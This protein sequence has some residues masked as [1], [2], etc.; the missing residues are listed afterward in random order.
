MKK[1][2]YYKPKS[3]AEVWELKDK[4]PNSRYIAGG[5]DVMVKI[6]SRLLAP[7]ALISLRDIPELK[8]IS[9][10]KNIR[11]GA[12][13]TITELIENIE[14][15]RAVPVL[16]EAAKRIGSLQ[17]R[18]V[19]TIG[20]NIGNCSPCAD[21]APSLLVLEASTVVQSAKNTRTIPLHEFFKGPGESCL[22]GQEIVVELLI[23][24]PG[25]QI[26]AISIK[27][28]RVQ[29]DLALA[30]VAVLMEIEGNF[31]KK[32]RVA[33]GSVAP[34]PLRLIEVEKFLENTEITEEKI[35]EA[36]RIAMECV[37]PISDVRTTAEYRRQLVGVYV[38]NAIQ[39]LIYGGRN[40]KGN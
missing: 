8:N 12:G 14:L 13:S 24:I 37:S 31:C 2:E 29:M 33:A 18:N 11:I 4:F 35:K 39:S 5:T 9:V 22:S 15:Q 28:G 21:T 30:S 38:K 26:K 40:E 1:I 6:K 34:V 23:D 36:Q 32:I 25:P 7:D 20:G 3:L 19:A 17:I 27:K 10:G 16:I